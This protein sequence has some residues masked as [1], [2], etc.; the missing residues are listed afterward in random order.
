MKSLIIMLLSLACLTAIAET[1]QQPSLTEQAIQS[2]KQAASDWGKVAKQKYHQG[3]TTAK[4]NWP[5]I[6]EKAQQAL[7]HADQKADAWLQQHDK[8]KQQ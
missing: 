6:K 1:Q 5:A 7:E 8:T 3:K 4:K 2:S